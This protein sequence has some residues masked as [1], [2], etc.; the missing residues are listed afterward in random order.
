MQF[1]PYKIGTLFYVERGRSEGEEQVLDG[2]FTGEVDTWGKR[3][4]IPTPSD[5]PY[6]FFDDEV[7]AWEPLPQGGAK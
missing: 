7:S 6:Y 2:Y 4:F 1:E 3:T 5:V